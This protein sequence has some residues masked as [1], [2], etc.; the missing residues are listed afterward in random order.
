MLTFFINASAHN[1]VKATL[2]SRLIPYTNIR[3]GILKDCYS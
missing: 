2:C 1:E 3:E